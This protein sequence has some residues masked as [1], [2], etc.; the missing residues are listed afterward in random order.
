MEKSRN[1]FSKVL[2]FLTLPLLSIVVQ[3]G[4]ITSDL[5][6]ADEMHDKYIKG[7]QMLQGDLDSCRFYLQQVKEQAEKTGDTLFWYYTY[8]IEAQLAYFEDDMIHAIEVANKQSDLV[9]AY[10]DTLGLAL[11][12][13]MLSTFYGDVGLYEQSQEMLQQCLLD[14]GEM[15]HK[16]ENR[17]STQYERA[18]RL[19]NTL[20][21][22]I[23]MSYLHHDESEKAKEY[24]TK[25]Q[26][27]F[28][29]RPGGQS[30]Y[31]NAAINRNLSLV[32]GE[33]DEDDKAL[34]V[35]KKAVPYF[36]KTN[37]WRM[38]G[39][40][41]YRLGKAYYTDNKMILAERYLMK[42]DSIYNSSKTVNETNMYNLIMLSKLK[43]EQNRIN[44]A[45]KW[46]NRGE[47]LVDNLTDEV[48]GKWYLACSKTYKKKG[49]F[50]LALRHHEKYTAIQDSIVIQDRKSQF[51][52]SQLT[53]NLRQ[54]KNLDSLK[55]LRVESERNAET[56]RAEKANTRNIFT[57][58]I[59]G[60]I[61][62]F[63]VAFILFAVNRNR[64]IQKQKALLNQEYDHLKEFTENASHEMQT[65]MA[66]I[67]TKLTRLLNSKNLSPEELMDIDHVANSTEQLSKLNQSLLLITKIENRQF[68]QDEIIQASDVVNHS[69]DHM[70]DL[71]EAKE[72]QFSKSVIDD[73]TLTGNN[74]LFQMVVS[75]LIGNAVK[76]NL[77]AGVLDV[78]LTEKQFKVTN[79][80]KELNMEPHRLFERFTRG[81]SLEKGTGLGLSI[82]KKVCDSHNWKVTYEQMGQDHILTV[83]F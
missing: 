7:L 53:Y 17:D 16:Y 23:G 24:L 36:T 25:A 4:R 49:D 55:I 22:D 78:Q 79:S 67:H 19:Y 80:G 68:P 45:L 44:D 47:A 10:G 71:I 74:I 58:V 38:L 51:L 57:L 13:R 9:A 8:Q 15:V 12:N 30:E 54:Q 40:C 62:L 83:D 61:I 27:Y 20:L 43:L 73:I 66:L 5:P 60:A 75:N 1:T 31:Y 76:Y 35:Y 28:K 56:N 72:I 6:I 34:E 42:A 81:N 59:A 26:T 3:G 65:P 50:G 41:N 39:D 82:V 32:Y 64:I 14:V 2:L 46:L 70:K 69:L 48:K 77:W 11:T 52:K 37:Q 21:H 18:L 33:L 29:T 63:A